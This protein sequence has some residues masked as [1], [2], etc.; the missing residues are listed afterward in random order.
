[1]KHDDAGANPG[2][3]DSAQRGRLA[4]Y[5]ALI[6]QILG[7]DECEL[8]A[9]YHEQARVGHVGPKVGKTR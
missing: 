7:V 6:A 9:I 2:S 8:G 1:M 5:D 3:D 4:L